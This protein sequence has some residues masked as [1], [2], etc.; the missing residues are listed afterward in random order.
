MATAT[1]MTFNDVIQRYADEYFAEGNRETATAKE[2]AI[3][4]IQTGRWEPPHDLMLRQCREDVA[5][6][7]REHYIA[8]N[9]GRPVRA[10]H[11]ARIVEDGRQRHLWADIRTATH[12]FMHSALQQRREQIV[13]D[14]V[15]LKRDMDFFNEIRPDGPEVQLVFDF[16]DDL[17][18]AE[19]DKK[20]RPKQP[21]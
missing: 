8:D 17:E 18:E 12:K 4:L 1:S 2:I 19:F 10:K 9:S 21:R 13:G 6:A 11:V 3:W 15:Q 16:T 7:L 5:R 14:C 20:F